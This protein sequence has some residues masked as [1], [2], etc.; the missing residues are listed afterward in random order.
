MPVYDTQVDA[1]DETF[2]IG[3]CDTCSAGSTNDG[4]HA[5]TVRAVDDD[6]CAPWVCEGCYANHWNGAPGDESPFEWENTDAGQEESYDLPNDIPP[7][8]PSALVL[9]VLGAR[10]NRMIS[11]EQELGMGRREV[12]TRL[13]LAGHAVTDQVQP[14]HGGSPGGFCYV[15]DDGSVDS[16]VIYGRLDLSRNEVA[17]SFEA[18]L[19]VVRGCIAEGEARLDMRCGGHIHVDVGSQRLSADQRY[20]M[21]DVESLYHLWNSL[22]D[23]IYRLGSANWARHRTLA[24]PSSYA[25]PSRKGHATMRDLGTY[26]EH[27]RDSLN[28]SNYLA[29]RSYCQCG[30]FAYS[31]WSECSC[32]LPKATVEFRVFNG[33]ANLR[34]INAYT[35]LCLAL[36]EYAKRNRVTAEERPVNEW[37]ATDTVPETHLEKTA[38]GLRF[39]LEDLQ[40]T[41]SEMLNLRYCAEKSSLAEIVAGIPVKRRRPRR[42]EDL[43]TA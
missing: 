35:A 16:E 2:N 18:A 40:L 34:K 12:A 39:I 36:V 15:E 28:L 17:A 6:D 38:D 21:R 29:S 41:H 19:N 1:Y 32:D 37:T 30:A 9:P 43:V 22:E 7:P 8:E 4:D 31:E 3:Q 25:N 14:Y 42:V 13:Y 26:L 27:S 10:A 11:F 24:A 5:V 20:G 23:V 33:T